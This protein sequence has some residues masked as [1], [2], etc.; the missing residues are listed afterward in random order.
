M[1]S[2]IVRLLSVLGAIILTGSTATYL[3]VGS[4]AAKSFIYGS[5]VAM[6]GAI[7]LLWRQAQ[8]ERRAVNDAVWI[9]RHAY[10]AAIERYIWAAIML[11]L[12]FKLL[13]LVPLWLMVGFIVGQVA[14]LFVSISNRLRTKNDD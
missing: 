6:I 9:V 12:G 10:K 11:A 5:L 1:C 3:L 14:W 8:A 7:I 13:E 2:G 4:P